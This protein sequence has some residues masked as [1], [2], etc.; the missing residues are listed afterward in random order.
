MDRERARLQ[1]HADEPLRA[2]RIAAHVDAG[3]DRRATVGPAEPLQDLDRGRLSRAIRPEQTE[4]L[5]LADIEA[6]PAHRLDVAV[7]LPQVRDRHDR[8]G[9]RTK[10]P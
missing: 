3:D 6:D 4:D 1:L 5:A 9:Q 7:A 8:S 2:F 10:A